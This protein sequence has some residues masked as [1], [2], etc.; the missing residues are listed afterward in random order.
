MTKGK[1]RRWRK[2]RERRG[3][4]EGRNG[5]AELLFLSHDVT[6]TSGVRLLKRG[7][8]K[9]EDFIINRILLH[10]FPR[11]TQIYSL[12]CFIINHSSQ[13][14]SV[15]YFPLR[16]QSIQRSLNWL[17]WC[18]TCQRKNINF[19]SKILLFETHF[20]SFRFTLDFKMVIFI[21]I[22]ECLKLLFCGNKTLH[23]APFF[24]VSSWQFGM[25]IWL[26]P[27]QIAYCWLPRLLFSKRAGIH[28]T[29]LID[30]PPGH[31]Q[32]FFLVNFL[33]SMNPFILW[34]ILK[35][36]RALSDKVYRMSTFLSI[37][38]FVKFKT[39]FCCWNFVD[40]F[41]WRDRLYQLIK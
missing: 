23:I 24:M 38:F 12:L 28:Y 19:L 26:L 25:T 1:K 40:L 17:E 14:E 30:D 4:G 10:S 6:A 37:F 3:E 15:A 39:Y 20:L 22:P 35:G 33:Q 21:P 5:E 8:E 13:M 29:C 32:V 31:W 27:R 16:M 36:F 18:V 41:I 9:R 34:S 11:D 2:R 7:F